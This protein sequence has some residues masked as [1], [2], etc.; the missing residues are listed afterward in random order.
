[1]RC[2]PLIA[3]GLV[4]L[5][6][7]CGG[8]DETAATAVEQRICEI[9]CTCGTRCEIVYEGW[10]AF[11]GAED[12]ELMPKGLDPT[13]EQCEDTLV[14]QRQKPGGAVS[15]DP[16]QGGGFDSPLKL[17]DTD[18]CLKALDQTG[19]M[20]LDWPGVPALALPPVCYDRTRP[21]IEK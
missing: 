1:M 16:V 21:Q 14:D 20:M 12:L 18:V 5:L 17:F 9:A 7:A 3:P 8:S 15:F 11:G 6:I 13:A 10:Y 19:C 2:R 4:C